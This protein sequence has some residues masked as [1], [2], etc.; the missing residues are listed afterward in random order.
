[1]ACVATTGLGLAMGL[2]LDHAVEEPPAPAGSAE[3][4]A[5]PLPVAA[6][7]TLGAPDAVATSRSAFLALALERAAPEAQLPPAET[8]LPAGRTVLL[9][10]LQAAEA[11]SPA[12]SLKHLAMLADIEPQAGTS[13][14][15]PMPILRVA[16]AATVAIPAPPRGKA[17]ARY[18]VEYAVFARERSAEHLR[19]AL[20]ALHLE[21]RVV[22]THAPDGRRLWR[23]RSALAER[24]GA[25]ADARLARQ[26]LG[27]KPLL[28]RTA[29]RSEPRV[30]YWVQFGAFP[31]IAPAVRLQQVLADNGV[32]ASVRNIRTSAGKPLFLVRSDGFP[33]RKLAMLVGEL[34]GS[35]AKVAFFVGR[36]PLR[37]HLAGHRAAPRGAA[38]S[39]LPHHRHAVPPGG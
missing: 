29:P 8:N 21:T 5:A 19:D 22:A 26:R 38:G 35:A 10:L 9:P 31:S 18:W 27:L 28:H 34:G 37:R 7:D 6:I 39:S 32:K 1:M 13:A 2:Y 30:Q 11:P 33:D 23:V 17:A 24:T 15:E 16:A 14:G 25:E 4:S 12:L 36:S 20:A 3:S